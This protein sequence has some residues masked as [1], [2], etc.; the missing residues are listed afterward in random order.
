MKITLTYLLL[1]FTSLY[2]FANDGAYYVSGNQLIPVEETDISVKKEV[3]TIKRKNKRQ[4]EVSV[5]YEFYNPGN[6]KSIIVGFEASSPGG[7]TDGRPKNGQHPN[8]SD[9]K[10]QMNKTILP[11]KVA[12]VND[13]LYY[14]HG[15]FATV[16]PEVVNEASGENPDFYY[17]YY[18]TAKFKK[19]VNIIR[20]TYTCDLSASVD[21]TY[22]FDYILTAANRWKNKQIDD[23][24]LII[25][26]GEYQDFY[27]DNTPFGQS[28]QWSLNGEGTIDEDIEYNDY[29][30]YPEKKSHRTDFHMR[31][32]EIIY[33]AINFRP[34]EELKIYAYRPVAFMPQPFNYQE[35]PYISWMLVD[36]VDYEI[37][38]TD[39]M[40]KRILKNLPFARKGYVF[41][42]PEIKEFYSA[43]S[44]Y[45]P[46]PAFSGNV[47]DLTKEE[48]EWV[49]HYS[50]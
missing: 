48:Q 25:D 12:I 29:T 6:T 3:L 41:T 46:D 36:D 37:D 45:T 34:R 11:Y 23:F 27:I 2:L 26:M 14:H 20:H 4:V 16:S 44:W 35:F 49:K 1:A 15:E 30:V 47:S 13:S 33:K 31:K 10:I 50:E 40:S 42:S 8:I 7:D 28:P 43:Q 17:V 22:R 19:G 21:Y 9:F 24:T 39:S 32:G 5:Y 18:F 38:T